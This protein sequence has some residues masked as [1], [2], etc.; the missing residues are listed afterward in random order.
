[1]AFGG[2]GVARKENFVVFVNNTLP[3]QKVRV[4]VYKKHRGYAEARPLEILR[5]SPHV[6]DSQSRHFSPL[7]GCRHKT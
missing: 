5:D 2:K 7:W 3:G 6:V 4:L 1:M